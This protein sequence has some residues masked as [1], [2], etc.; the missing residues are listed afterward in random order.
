MEKTKQNIPQQNQLQAINVDYS[1]PIPP[2][3]MLKGYNEI[4]P[5]LVDRIVITAEKQSIHRQS[6]EHKVINSDNIN[7]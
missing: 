3:D 6:M 4:M 2:P 1:G 5:G 7:L